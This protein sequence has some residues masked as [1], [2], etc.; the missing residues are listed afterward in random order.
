MTI[1]NK[2]IILIQINHSEDHSEKILPLGI[3]S[4]GSAL[5]KN[6][7]DVELINI[8]EKEIDQTATAVIDKKPFCVGLSV[9]TGRQT[10]YSAKLS[11]K[12]KAG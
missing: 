4:V 5:K 8:T 11:Q 6:G 7:F 1:E 3:L 10:L 12:I 9:M 2:K